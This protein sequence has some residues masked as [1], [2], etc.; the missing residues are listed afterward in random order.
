MSGMYV[1]A[2]FEGAKGSHIFD[3]MWSTL[4]KGI[5]PLLSGPSFIV[6][7]SEVGEDAVRDE[8]WKHNE[9]LLCETREISEDQYDALC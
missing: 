8:I 9:G 3:A 7:F 5:R 1:F 2:E 6:A 4:P